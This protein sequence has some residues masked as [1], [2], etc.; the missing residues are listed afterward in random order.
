MDFPD[1]L[2]TQKLIGGIESSLTALAPIMR[3]LPLRVVPLLLVGALAVPP[4]QADVYTW[5]D[6]SGR[7]NV[8]NIAPPE[9]VHPPHQR[10]QPIQ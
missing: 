8:S 5:T 3:S 10:G 7:L 2:S 6:P 1:R 9:G 4:A